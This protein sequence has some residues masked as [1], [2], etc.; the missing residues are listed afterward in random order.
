MLAV[1]EHLLS[2]VEKEEAEE[3]VEDTKQTH[4]TG[5]S[6]EQQEQRQPEGVLEHENLRE[7]TWS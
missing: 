4:S 5:S 6:E 2:P 1:L 3:E 7:H